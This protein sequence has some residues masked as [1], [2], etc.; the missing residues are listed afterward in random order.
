M[1]LVN[2]E[3]SEEVI[4]KRTYVINKRMACGLVSCFVFALGNVVGFG[5]A[6]HTRLS[7]R[8]V[9]PAPFVALSLSL[10]CIH[11]SHN[12]IG[13]VEYPSTEEKDV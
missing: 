6:T 13:L 9:G 1:A 11:W 10:A 7:P 2:C 3:R 5:A 8:R 12:P 4:Y